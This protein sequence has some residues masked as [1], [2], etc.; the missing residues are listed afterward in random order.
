MTTETLAPRRVLPDATRGS[1]LAWLVCL[2]A[3]LFFFYEF[4]QMQ[5]FNAI[6]DQLRADFAVDATELGLLSSTYLIADMLFLIPAG[7]I[8][9]RVSTRK[10]ILLATAICVTGTFGFAMSHSVM[11]A[12]IFHALSGFGHSFCFLSCYVLVSRWFPPRQY[13][14]VLGLVVT[15]AFTGGMVA[16]TPLA[17]LAAEYGWRTA[18]LMDAILGVMVMSIIYFQVQDY[19]AERAQSSLDEMA[20]NRGISFLSSLK[21]AMNNRQNWFCG[22]YTAAFNLPIMVLSAV[23]GSAYLQ[24]VNHLDN[25]HATMVTMMLFVGSVFGCPIV[26][27]WSDTVGK[28]KSPMIIG[29]VLSLVT[30][31]LIMLLPHWSFDQ[32]L[33]LFF[34][35]GFFTSSQVITYPVLAESNPAAVTGLAF[36][37]AATVIMGAGMMAQPLFGWIMD[38]NWSGELDALTQGRLYSAHA[39]ETAMLMFP[40]AFLIGL[41]AIG[42]AREPGEQK[43]ADRV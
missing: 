5:M 30:M 43:W 23:W 39:F 13:A 38:L 25:T 17:M 8:L 3:A 31:A 18:L 11:S 42:L 6:N 36:G 1:R 40:I 9:D 35:L 26:G 7:Y 15:M 41:M 10:V 20:K 12:A 33:G 34:L 2:S 19:P 28:R 14:F 24:H 37:V 29:G 32:L 21:Q 16:Q 4:I 27:Y 22:I